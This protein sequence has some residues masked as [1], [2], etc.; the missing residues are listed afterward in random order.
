MDIEA[1]QVAELVREGKV[2][3]IDVREAYE[4]NEG[5][6]PGARHLELGQVDAQAD[7]I[8]RET[9]VVFYC[10]VGG[11]SAMAANAFRQAGY[12]AYTMTGGLLEWDAQGLPLEPEG[13][14][15]ADH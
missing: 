14:H 5:R 6:I 3:L 15:V 12:D 2:Q 11:R 8:H 7:T 4:W 9:P 10:R 1:G 13:G